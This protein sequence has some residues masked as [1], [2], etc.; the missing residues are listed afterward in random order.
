MARICS[1]AVYSF[2]A[3]CDW[4]YKVPLDSLPVSVQWALV[5]SILVLALTLAHD[6]YLDVRNSKQGRDD[7]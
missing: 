3:Y 6:C 4:K 1:L 2:Y 5:L 7:K